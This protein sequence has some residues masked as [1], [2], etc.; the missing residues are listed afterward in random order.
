M[1][2]ALTLS[3]MIEKRIKAEVARWDD[4]RDRLRDAVRDAGG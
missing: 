4:L 1:R 3:K 2:R